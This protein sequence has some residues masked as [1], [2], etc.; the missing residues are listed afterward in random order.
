MKWIFTFISNG[1]ITNGRA[2][3]SIDLCQHFS[4]KLK[5]FAFE[6]QTQLCEAI[7]LSATQNK[8][9]NITVFDIAIGAATTE[10][11]LH[12]ASSSVHVSAVAREV[13]AKSFTVNC[14]SL[15][16][17]IYIKKIPPPKL[18][19]MDTE[20]GELD[21]FKGSQRMLKEFAPTIIF[22]SDWTD[23]VIL[24]RI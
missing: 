16:D 18:I 2:V 17:L 3:V 1:K 22:E 20:G 11:E 5:C 9:D 23:G 12:F 7:A 6:P 21:V 15:D 24:V 14:Y 8:F 13:G 4:D 10:I 19:K